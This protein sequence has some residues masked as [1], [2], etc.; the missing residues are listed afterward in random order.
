M[1]S[2][3]TCQS[4]V[5]TLIRTIIYIIYHLEAPTEMINSPVARPQTSTQPTDDFKIASK[6]GSSQRCTFISSSE[7]H[8][9]SPA[10]VIGVTAGAAPAEGSVPSSA[11]GQTARAEERTAENQ[12]AV[13]ARGGAQQPPTSTQHYPG[14]CSLVLML[15]QF[16][17]ST[18]ILCAK[19]HPLFLFK[20]IY[21]GWSCQ[22]N[23]VPLIQDQLF[24][25]HL[26]FFNL[27]LL[28]FFLFLPP[29][30]F[31][32]VLFL[33]LHFHPLVP[34]LDCP[35]SRQWG[36]PKGTGLVPRLFL[37]LLLLLLMV[38]LQHSAPPIRR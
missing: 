27:H 1:T 38:L 36:S 14:K 21:K 9:H 7:L 23:T 37:L 22:F 5:L 35:V 30:L 18:H 16:P 25:F 29:D 2:R 33:V 24:I 19:V 20:V 11:A 34:A 26:I 17:L 4:Q 10:G 32:L 3:E 15:F 13:H 28:P 12:A 31:Y 8:L 6:L